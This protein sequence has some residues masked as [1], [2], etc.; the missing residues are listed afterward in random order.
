M[1]TVH[2]YIISKK[3]SIKKVMELCQSRG[4]VDPAQNTDMRREELFSIQIC[5][6]QDSREYVIGNAHLPI[7][8]LVDTIVQHEGRTGNYDSRDKKTKLA[9]TLFI[10]GTTY[11][12]RENCIIGKLQLTLDY[13]TQKQYLTKAEARALAM[14][15]DARGDYD[16]TLSNPY[17][18]FMHRETY[19]N[20]KIPLNAKLSI[21]VDRV[22]NL[23]ESIEN[24]EHFAT[25][26]HAAGM[27]PAITGATPGYDED[28]EFLHALNASTMVRNKT[29]MQHLDRRRVLKH[30][31]KHGL[32]LIVRASVFEEDLDLQ[33]K[34]AVNADGFDQNL[35]KYQT[36]I[37]YSSL[38]PVFGEIFEMSLQMNTRIFEY[39]KNKRAVFEVRHY[40]IQSAKQKVNKL[41]QSANWT[42]DNHVIDDEAVD[43]KMALESCDYI[44]LGHVKVPLLQLITKNNGVDGDFT[45]FDEFN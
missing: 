12:Q 45:I 44:T 10:Y 13:S 30:I 34:F 21:L 35:S 17:S 41:R 15:R 26:Q 38:N 42:G 24:I 43:D 5:L 22:S 8:D 25:I 37:L 4:Q 1:D 31:L 18:A 29:D 27:Q 32:N 19:V 11:S 40:I 7:E 16:G 20:R 3:D 14:Q 28:E 6:Y 39:L 23:K 2:S 9:R 36:R 33:R